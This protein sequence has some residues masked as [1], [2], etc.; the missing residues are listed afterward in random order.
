VFCFFGWANHQAKKQHA[1][2]T[3]SDVIAAIENVLSNDYHDE[4]DLFLSWP[5]RV[6]YL[7]SMRQRCIAIS[8][9]YSGKEKGKHIA[10]SGESKLLLILDELRD[11]E[12]TVAPGSANS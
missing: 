7:E 6:S 12:G 10:T 11:R 4:W 3:R 8:E 5:I 1:A 9:E 2:F